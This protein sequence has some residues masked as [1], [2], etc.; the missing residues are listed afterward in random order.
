MFRVLDENGKM[1]AAM[2]AGGIVYN[3]ENGTLRA[4]G[5]DGRRTACLN[6]LRS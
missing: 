6:W 5:T 4:A 2:A 1:R 3:D